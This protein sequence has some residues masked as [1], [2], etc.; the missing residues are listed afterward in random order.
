MDGSSAPLGAVARLRRGFDLPTH[1]RTQGSVPVYAANGPI[2]WHNEVAVRGPGV[3]TGRSGSIGKVHYVE[4]DYWPLNTSLY[5]EDFHGNDPEFVCLLL[6]SVDLIR[7]SSSTAVPTLNRNIAHKARVMVPPI[8]EQRRIVAKV[9]ELMALCDE[10]EARQKTRRETRER[11]VASAL[12]KLTSA[13]DAAEFNAHCR[14]GK[15]RPAGSIELRVSPSPSKIPYG[16]FSPVRLQM[17]RQWRP[18]TTSRGLSA[19]HIRLMRPSYT[20]PQLQL[21]GIRDPRRDY[22]FENLSVQCGTTPN[23]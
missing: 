7:F 20:P 14:V 22:P 13:R 21:P 17:D 2:G 9:D 5:V 18:S 15:G 4:S 8:T 19:V 23:N 11:L 10:L 3:V 12:D 6:R 16:G 1:K